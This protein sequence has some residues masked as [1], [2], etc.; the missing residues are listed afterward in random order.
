MKVSDGRRSGQNGTKGCKTFVVAILVMKHIFAVGI[1]GACWVLLTVGYAGFVIRIQEIASG[2]G[3]LDVF[4]DHVAEVFAA[5]VV[6]LAQLRN[7]YREEGRERWLELLSL[8]T[9]WNMFSS[10]L[11]IVT[12]FTVEAFEPGLA[13]THVA[14]N[15][16]FALS[17]ICT[18]R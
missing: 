18:R 6:D 7:D 9:L 10:S 14:A 17:L 12:N 3:A 1:V 8:R 4:V 2:A 16:V 13:V 5:A 11:L 15:C